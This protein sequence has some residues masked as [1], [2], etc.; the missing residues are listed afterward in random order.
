MRVRQPVDKIEAHIHK[1][2][3]QA[4]LRQDTVYN[5]FSENS[6]KMSY[7]LGNVEYFESCEMDSRV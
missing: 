5:P 6:K 4:N 7:D 3:F 2:D 1:E